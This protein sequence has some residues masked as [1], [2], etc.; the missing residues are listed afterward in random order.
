MGLAMW[1]SIQYVTTGLTLVA[2]GIAAAAWLYKSSFETK[3]RLIQSAS[4][5]QR[6]DLVRQTLEFF[7]IKTDG[8]TKDQKF[9]LAL[10]QIHARRE[11]FRIAAIVICIIA[12]VLASISAFAIHKSGTSAPESTPSR[13][14]GPASTAETTQPKQ[15]PKL[16]LSRWPLGGW[17]ITLSNP[18]AS[19][20]AITDAMLIAKPKGA[21]DLG[22]PLAFS[23]ADLPRAS[24]T[25]LKLTLFD[26]TQSGA[27]NLRALQTVPAIDMFNSST[28]AC[29][30]EVTAVDID[31]GKHKAY[32]EFNCS[33]LPFPRP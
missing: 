13:P 3:E 7:D 21:T 19:D 5:S 33:R 11:R 25:A 16:T 17:E 27:S 14:P 29:L 32:E 10:E 12:V 2:F 28:T 8:L 31:G 23:R 22:F 24:V 1:E 15:A 4:E 30:V 20:L 9:R 18:N 26:Q 6:A